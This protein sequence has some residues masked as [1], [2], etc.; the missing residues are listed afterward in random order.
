MTSLA[1]LVLFK[2]CP[3]LDLL[4]IDARLEARLRLPDFFRPGILGPAGRWPERLVTVY[5]HHVFLQ[6]EMTYA[7]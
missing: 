4:A 1:S 2:L 5:Q 7:R 3:W 6:K